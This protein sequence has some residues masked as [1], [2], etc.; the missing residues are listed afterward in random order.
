MEE[1]DESSC[2][3]GVSAERVFHVVLA[4]RASGLAEVL[5]DRAEYGDLAS[6]EARREDE[7]VEAV[8]LG[9]AAPGPGER[10][11]KRLPHLLCLELGVL[12]VA[13]PE[14]EDPDGIAVAWPDL[15]RPLVGDL[16][17]HVFEQRQHVRQQDR[18]TGAQQFEREMVSR[19]EERKVEA[20]CQV[21]D[22]VELLHALDFENRLARGEVLAV[23]DRKRIAV[24]LEERA[25]L[26][27]AEL[28][29]EGVAEV[30]RPRSGRRGEARFELRDVELDD[31][32]WVDIDD[33][34][35]A[36]QHRLRDTGRVVGV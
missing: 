8:I 16:Y 36:G 29:D 25:G 14:V 5:G 15:I 21:A 1:L 6:R 23:G 20:H 24:A 30:V 28:L 22:G 13:E 2:D 3:L 12:L 27:L 4:E 33:E 19:R 7:P 31:A 9:L 10:V 18:L 35:Q 11:L 32:R 34:V 17:A 26:F